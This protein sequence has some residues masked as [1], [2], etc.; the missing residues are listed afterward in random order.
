MSG[1]AGSST[2]GLAVSPLVSPRNSPVRKSRFFQ[3][4]RRPGPD[5]SSARQDWVH[6]HAET[7]KPLAAYR[8][9]GWRGSLGVCNPRPQ[10]GARPGKCQRW[11]GP[12]GFFGK[13]GHKLSAIG[14][15]YRTA[16]SVCPTCSTCSICSVCTTCSACSVCPACSACPVSFSCHRFCSP[17][18]GAGVGAASGRPANHGSSLLHIPSPPGLSRLPLTLPWVPAG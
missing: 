16:C 9:F 2:D 7:G 13:V 6:E 18:F 14:L 10:G 3:V 15:R 1:C 11:N 12:A 5:G 8:L 17:P 4:F